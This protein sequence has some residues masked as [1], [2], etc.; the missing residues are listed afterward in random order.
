MSRVLGT[1]ISALIRSLRIEWRGDP[2][3][4]RAVVAFWHAKMLAGWW[5]ARKHAVALVSRSKDGERLAQILE[6]WKYKL[7]RGSSGKGGSEALDNAIELVRIGAAKRLAITPDGPRGPREVMKRGAFIA[8]G[9]LGLPLIFL[10]IT[11]EHAK[12]L[13]KS[14]DRFEVPYPLSKVIID[15]HIIDVSDF[16]NEK[17]DQQEYLQKLSYTLTPIFQSPAS[18][19]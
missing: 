19:R 13:P 5:V 15:P 16:P 9:E 12:V 17:E 8:A 7:V 14:W 6:S 11:Y 2:L 3:P 10:D 4:E 1:G 18:T